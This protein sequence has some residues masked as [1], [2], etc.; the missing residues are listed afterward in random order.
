MICAAAAPAAVFVALALVAA[1][2]PPKDRV[3]PGGECF[4]A[5]DCAPGLVCVEQEN[6]SRVCSDDITRVAGRTAP[7]GAR[8]EEADGSDD[9]ATPEGGP[10]PPP[11]TPNPNPPTPPPTP[12]PNPPPDAGSDADAGS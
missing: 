8:Q 3:G 1:C 7:D 9:G 5:T 6:R 12:P 4:L 10:A 2:G 11:P